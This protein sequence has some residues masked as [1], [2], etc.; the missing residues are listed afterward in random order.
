MA[1]GL[2]LCPF[3]G[4]FSAGPLLFNGWAG[5]HFPQSLSYGHVVDFQARDGCKRGTDV[6]REFLANRFKHFFK[7]IEVLELISCIS[8]QPGKD[9]LEL[10]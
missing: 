7:V 2:R 6:L 9:L 5:G 3:H 4:L 1:L 10:F 8:F